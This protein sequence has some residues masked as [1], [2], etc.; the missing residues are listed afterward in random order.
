[1]SNAGI[2]GKYAVDQSVGEEVRGARVYL[3]LKFGKKENE[4]LKSH[5]KADFAHS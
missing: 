5:S 2:V 1:M 4:M 3:M